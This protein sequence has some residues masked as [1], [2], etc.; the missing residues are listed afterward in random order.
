MSSNS[1]LTAS[2]SNWISPLSVSHFQ[3]E[4]L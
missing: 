1:C 2:S 4:N 3:Y